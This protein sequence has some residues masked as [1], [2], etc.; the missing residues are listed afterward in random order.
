[1]IDPL[2]V[3]IESSRA[4]HTGFLRCRNISASRPALEV[5]GRVYTYG[6]LYAE[7]ARFAAALER[8][9]VPRP[10]MV[11]IFADHSLTAFAGILG[12]LLV[13]A[14]YVPMNRRFPAARCARMCELAGVD[15]AIVDRRGLVHAAETLDHIDIQPSVIFG[16]DAASAAGAGWIRAFSTL[17]TAPSFTPR[18]V[19]SDHAAYLLFTSGTTG[20]P[21]GVAVTHA[22]AAHYVDALRH[23][24]PVRETDRCSQTFD[25]TFDLSVHDMF[26]T[27][28]AGACLVVP[29]PMDL[30]TP[31]KFIRDRAISVWFSVPSLA[32]LARRRGAMQ[33]NSLPTLRLSQFCGE[34]LPSQI[35]AAWSIAAPES[36]V[37]NLYGPTELTIACLSHVFA[38]DPVSDP[39]GFVPIG[40]PLDGLGCA[41][42]RDAVESAGANSSPEQARELLVC[43]PQTVPGYWRDAERTAERFVHLLCEDGNTRTFYK[44]G[45]LVRRLDDG[46][47]CYVGRA[48]T[49][50]KIGG[51]RVELGE[52]EGVIAGHP[53]V[54]QVAALAW[55]PLPASQDSIV[56]FIAA[57]DMLDEA[58]LRASLRARLP[59]Y[60]QPR[61]IVQSATL[62]L[63]NNG[64]IDRAALQ[65]LL[66]EGS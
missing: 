19:L 29:G 24:F 3:D 66:M 42:L 65:A 50:V 59:D 46:T 56:A 17:D 62:P 13:G 6:E 20:T 35:A 37:V 54:T 49:Q 2:T 40:R 41:L 21:K 51:F 16:D 52:I 15:A 25:L 44:T 30:L 4:L 61:R 45:D 63:N 55:P 39:D 9:A 7:A 58:G 38:R 12:A 22:N 34:P 57:T 53:G 10:H 64:K 1:M 33:P 11:A 28:S 23:R 5:E 18:T 43:G 14:T 48:D 36:L 26:V 31:L 32:A 60:M 47:Y 8:S 27:W